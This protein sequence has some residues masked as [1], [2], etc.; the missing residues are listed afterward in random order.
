MMAAEPAVEYGIYKVNQSKNLVASLIL[1]KYGNKD[2]RKDEVDDF[3]DGKIDIL[4]VYNMLLTGFDA[5]RLK[6]LYIGRIIKDHN[7]LQTLTRVNRPYKKFR[8]GY[9]V[10][11][12][13]ITK[14]FDGMFCRYQLK[15]F[16]LN[17]LKWHFCRNSKDWLKN[18]P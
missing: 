2:T 18:Y 5:K 6:K 8:Y 7:L 15:A 13:D 16:R 17:Q 11:F 12:A 4:F 3:K 9:V 10:D 14:E 1:D